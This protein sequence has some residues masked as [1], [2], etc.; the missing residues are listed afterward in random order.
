MI[1]RSGATVVPIRFTGQNSR[2]Y[3]I[4]SLL[5]PTVRQG[6]LLYEVRAALGKAQSPIVG[7]AI[8]ADQMED[9]LAKDP[10]AFIAWLREHTLG[11]TRE[12]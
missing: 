6:L 1:Q 8:S 12:A 9:D 3:Q 2:A 10:R 11:L 5:S 4:A 7:T